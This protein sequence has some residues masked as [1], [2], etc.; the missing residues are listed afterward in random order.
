MLCIDARLVVHLSVI[1][2]SG[3]RCGIDA[4]TAPTYCRRQFKLVIGVGAEGTPEIE[5][6]LLPN[7]GHR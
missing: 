4:V 6:F 5:T 2:I 7:Y 3:V 1:F